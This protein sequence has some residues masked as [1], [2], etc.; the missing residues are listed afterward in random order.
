MR[1]KDGQESTV[2]TCDLAFY[3]RLHEAIQT[4]RPLEAPVLENPEVSQT[5]DAG[6]A[7]DS[8]SGAAPRDSTWSVRRRLTSAELSFA[9]ACTHVAPFY[10]TPKTPRP[11]M[12]NR[13]A[14]LGQKFCHY[15]REG[16]T[17]N[18]LLSFQQTNV[19]FTATESI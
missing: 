4:Q 18:D 15:L 6:A 12:S 3:P 2:S 5:H 1:H 16:R 9:F 17:L 7:A 13:N 8:G 19:S 14:L 11:A 10:T